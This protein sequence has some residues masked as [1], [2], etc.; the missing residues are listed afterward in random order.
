MLRL[1]LAAPSVHADAA[2]H[3]GDTPLLF[4]ASRG[5][6]GAVALLAKVPPLTCSA[7]VCSTLEATIK[8]DNLVCRRTCDA[9]QHLSCRRAQMLQR[10]MLTACPRC[11]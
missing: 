5:R 3:N 2:S 4:A 11:L 10:A 8:Y 9:L 7:A 6:L 1:L